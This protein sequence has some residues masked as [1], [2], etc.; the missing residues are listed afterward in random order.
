MEEKA[1]NILLTFVVPCYNVEKYIQ[2]CLDSIYACKLP[3]NCYEVLCIND[4]SPDGTAEILER[5]KDIHSNLYIVNHKVN[6]G[7]GGG[8]NTGILN[9]K[10]CYIW[11]VDSDDEV[12]GNG[13]SDALKKAMDE[14]L[15]VLCFNYSR[16]DEKGKDLSL[17]IVFGQTPVMD[18]YSFVKKLFGDSIVYH[19]G[20]VVRFLYRTDY[21]KEHNLFFPERVHWEDTVFM[22]KSLLSAERVASVQQVFYAYRVNSNSISAVFDRVYPA[23]WIYEFAFLAGRDLLQ[24]SED[25]EDESLMLAVKDA[26]VKKYING[27]PIP[28]FRTSKNERNRFYTIEGERKEELKPLKR[29]LA[30]FSK[31]LLYPVIGKMVAEGGA[32]LYRLRHTRK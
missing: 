31:L 15:D 18:G 13:F 19:M 2:R 5:N 17:H 23:Q 22:P 25:I 26:A 32:W 24:F 1:D 6:K 4:C 14:N 8:R 27:F 29:Y 11:F 3:E 9:A 12:A 30:P 10:G 16:I 20:Y 21:L 7:L 28:L